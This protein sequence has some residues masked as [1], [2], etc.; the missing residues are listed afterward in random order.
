MLVH[1]GKGRWMEGLES[2]PNE[3]PLCIQPIYAPPSKWGQDLTHY[4]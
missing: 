1:S 2:V 3:A 4:E